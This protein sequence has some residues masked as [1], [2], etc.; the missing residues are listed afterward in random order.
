M[1]IVF[2]A[3]TVPGGF[4]P[5]RRDD[6]DGTQEGLVHLAAV[7]ARTH[8]VTVV[9][10]GPPQ[11]CD[12]VRYLPREAATPEYELA[13]YYVCP[14]AVGMRLAPRAWLWTWSEGQLFNPHLFE[15]VIVPSRFVLRCLKATLP[16]LEPKLACIPYGY[17]PAEHTVKAIR[18]PQ[19]VLHTAS[20]DRGLETL[21][22]LW[23]QVVE[24]RP[25]AR[26][27]C[28]AGWEAFLARGGS[29][30]FRSAMEQLAA[31][32]PRVNM[33]KTRFT[34]LEMARLYREAGLWAYYCTGGENFCISA[35]KAQV[36]GAVPVVRRWGALQETVWSGLH[37]DTPEDF[38]RAL[39]AALDPA[40]QDVLRTH[41]EPGLA[42]TWEDVAASWEALLTMD[43]PAP[44]PTKLLQVPPTPQ[45]LVPRAGAGA[46]Q[47]MAEVAQQWASQVGVT[48]PWVMP[49]L[50]FSFGIALPK[51]SDGV[52]VGFEMEDSTKPPH[53][54]LAMLALPPT[55]PVLVVTSFGPWRAGVRKRHLARRDLAE[56]FGQQPDCAMRAVAMDGEGNGFFAT[57]FRH[58]ATKIAQRDL[59]R[60]RR[61]S[62]PRETCSVAFIAH[63]TQHDGAFLKALRSVVPLADEVLC[64]VNP[65]PPSIDGAREERPPDWMNIPTADLLADFE[66]ETKIPVRVVDGTC[67]HWCFDC[68]MMHRKGEMT[69]GHRLA[70][71][72][73]PRN[74]SIA[75]ARG[76]WVCW[77]DTDERLEAAEAL[78]KYL[79]P[80]AF[81]GYAIQ[82][83]H[84]SVNPPEASRVDW[85][86]RLFRR[87]PDGSPVGFRPEGP[88]DWPTF[89]PGARVRFAGIVHEHPGG[90]MTDADGLPLYTDGVSPVVMVTDAWI[91]HTGYLTE[92][93]RRAR[94]LRNWALM[95]S[96]AEKY[97]QRRLGL[98]LMLRDLSHHLRYQLERN[99]NRVT[100]EVVQYAEEAIRIW[101]EHFADRN[102]PFTQDAL[103]YASGAMAVLSQGWE[104]ELSF[105]ARKPEV[106]GD[107]SVGFQLNGRCTDV[108]EQVALFQARLGDLN[109][110]VG[111][112]L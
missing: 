102:E 96:C 64:A 84:H 22:R 45:D 85:P 13:I 27:V 60:V 99:Q 44:S 81:N 36:S 112:W 42:R 29:P 72:E 48:K 52:I 28:T 111:A 31:D 24:S 54:L 87:K 5:K 37:P 17:D 62:S 51:D 67:P 57:G 6:W 86:V 92:A 79:R 43:P 19:L 110:W 38:G 26:L 74:Q 83:H 76:D 39:I 47:R 94:F 53:E 30:Q 32:A 66:A 3:P 68:K 88:L 90:D 93:V 109:R 55:I 104:F 103:Q 10:D 56:L 20:P 82:Q 58:D 100:P 80:N 11:T 34:Q 89:H 107:E 71:F 35:L 18:N 49:S 63:P 73:T 75:F 23:P 65:E 41:I 59:G 61:T 2:V 7:L 15:R 1:K 95:A 70:G 4:S 97:P 105:K 50:G 46:P 40:T 101:K 12:G 33:G 8:Q 78:T 9:Y 69:Y 98:F 16:A 14:D 21:L 91:S 25:D 77:L 106:T 108:Q